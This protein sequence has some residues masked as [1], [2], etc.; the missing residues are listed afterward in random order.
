[1]SPGVVGVKMADAGQRPGVVPAR[2]L[3]RRGDGVESVS[4]SAPPRLA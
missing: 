4:M 3:L 1:M 2:R